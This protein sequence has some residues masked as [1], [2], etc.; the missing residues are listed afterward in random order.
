MVKEMRCPLCGYENPPSAKI[1]RSCGTALS[2][3][4]VAAPMWLPP[5]TK[6]RQGAYSVGRVL[7][8][9]G[10][11]ITYKGS[12][13]LLRRLIAIK[14]FCPFGCIRRGTSLFP[15]T[16]LSVED[17]KN[18]KQRFIFEARTLARIS[19][20]SVPKAYDVFE[21]NNTAYFVMEY[22][23]GESL[24][25]ILKR[26]QRLDEEEAIRY[27]IQVGEVL[28]T[29]HSSGIIHR[30]IKPENIIVC[31]DG[32]AR[33]IDFGAAREFSRRL[34]QPHSIIFTYGYAAP[35][36]LSS[37][38]RL[39]PFTDIYALSATLYQLLTGECPPSAPDRQMGIP[40]PDVRQLNPSVS[41]RVAEAIRIGME[42]DPAK[43]PQTATEFIKMLIGPSISPAEMVI[44][45]QAKPSPQQLPTSLRNLINRLPEMWQLM[46]EK[47]MFTELLLVTP[48]ERGI[49]RTYTSH[50]AKG[51]RYLIMGACDEEVLL[52]LTIS[53]YSP[54]EKLFA[55]SKPNTSKPILQVKTK[56]E[57]NYRL[58]FEHGEMRGD[59]GFFSAIVGRRAEN[60]KEMEIRNLGEGVFEKLF[61]LIENNIAQGYEIYHAEIDILNA[62]STRTLSVDLEE[63]YEYLIMAWGDELNIADLD[64]VVNLSDGR[65][66]IDKGLDNNPKAKFHINERGN[67]LIKAIPAKFH[68]GKEDGYYVLYIGR[69]NC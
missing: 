26:R 31:K 18:M 6:L 64:M 35:E 15:S 21:E 49:K 67:A 29:V 9:G 48:L 3:E 50:F 23:E 41:Q 33:L 7:G 57:G 8:Q 16:E 11:G 25:D 59:K 45:Q 38:G 53:L 20:P 40:L 61:T 30:D 14:E 65:E 12:H 37:I 44:P 46:R 66:I 36:Q 62:N 43:R 34:T 27:I 51:K 47:N 4:G 69:K 60:R 32:R 56:K 2:D 22:L 63:G 39:G 17:F 58:E 28:E 68:T 55:R 24:A 5:G 13:T 54:D 19:H 1:C 42:L 10:F 52:G